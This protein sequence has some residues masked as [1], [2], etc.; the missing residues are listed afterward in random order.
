MNAIFLSIPV[1]V[2]EISTRF[3]GCWYHGHLFVKCYVDSSLPSSCQPVCVSQKRK[4]SKGFCCS[5]YSTDTQHSE[6]PP[7]SIS[8]YVSF[9]LQDFFIM[10][11]MSKAVCVVGT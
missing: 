5:C 3:E 2:I 9:R 1:K 11:S 10:L 4:G 6:P 8:S 7:G